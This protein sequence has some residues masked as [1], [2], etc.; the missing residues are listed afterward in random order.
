MPLLRRRSPA[1]QLYLPGVPGD[2]IGKR[3]GET[4][5]T[6]ADAV[7]GFALPFRYLTTG[8]LRRLSHPHGRLIRNSSA[9]IIRHSNTF[10]P[11]DASPLPY[12]TRTRRSPCRVAS[13]QKELAIIDSQSKLRTYV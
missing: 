12:S 10:F 9:C 13:T 6:Y 3:P 8:G 2:Q 4:P 11:T 1:L 7:A 5:H